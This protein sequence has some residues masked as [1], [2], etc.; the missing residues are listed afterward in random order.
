MTV[1][2]F[3]AISPE[4]LNRGDF[5]G[6]RLPP[7]TILIDRT[8]IWGNPFF[9]GTRDQNC[10]D[11]EHWLP[12]QRDLMAKIGMLTG[13]HLMCHCAPERCHGLTLRRLANPHLLLN[14]GESERQ[15][16]A[17]SRRTYDNKTRFTPGRR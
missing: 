5:P 9:K 12:E 8:T 13:R 2:R 1:T 7:N 16:S 15:A 3:P 10:D 14:A 11:Y 6:K 17:I 4:I